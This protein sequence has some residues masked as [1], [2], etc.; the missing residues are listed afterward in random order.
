MAKEIAYWPNNYFYQSKLKNH[1]VD[2]AGLNLKPYVLLNINDTQDEDNG[3]LNT[4]EADFVANVVEM[5][6]GLVDFNSRSL[7]IGIITPYNKQKLIL[8]EKI[9]QV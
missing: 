7:S 6:V 4:Q 2:S 9:R 8:A 3:Y 5:V 1:P